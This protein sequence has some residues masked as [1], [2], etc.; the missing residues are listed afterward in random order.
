[1]LCDRKK[2]ILQ[3][4]I[5]DYVST[6]EPIGSRT[7][8]KRYDMGLS[9]ATIRNEMADLEELGYLQQPHTSSGRVPS[10]KGY[11]LYV[12]EL[13]INRNP[14]GQE[15]DT[16]RNTL[17]S[18][19]TAIEQIMKQASG[20]LSQLTQYTSIAVIPSIKKNA[21]KYIQ[22][23]PL[24]NCNALMVIVTGAGVVKNTIIKLPEAVN[25]NFITK[26]SNILNEKLHGLTIESI[27]L[28]LIQEIQS[29]MGIYRDM[30]MPVLDTIS[31]NIC[32]IED[33]NVYLEG[34]SNILNYPEY[35]NIEKAKEFINAV[36][37]KDVICRLLEASN[38]DLI[39]ISI[40]RENPIGQIEDC[41]IVSTTYSIGDRIIGK[42]G[43]IGPKRMDYPKVVTSVN[44]VRQYLYEVFE[45]WLFR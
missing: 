21:I 15:M 22:I 34:A 17:V 3:A 10:D 37:T 12:D 18:Q 36:E 26:F 8:A 28:P 33:N 4:I 14:S 43:V 2:R 39:K 19:I 6:A 40:G 25:N 16:I 7:I 38:G 41:G 1:M 45:D 11:R 9:S 20:L 27:T 42:I 13:M 5:D 30:L 23:I 24:D 31:L 32:N 35:N 29:E 44:A